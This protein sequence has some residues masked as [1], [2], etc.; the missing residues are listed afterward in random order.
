MGLYDAGAT[1]Y[2]GS[3]VLEQLLRVAGAHV[4]H[5]YVLARS[6]DGRG[7]RER[8]GRVLGSGLFHLVRRQHPESLRKVRGDESGGQPPT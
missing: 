8:V 2:L 6:R 7:P 1:G 5:V 3:V 4:S